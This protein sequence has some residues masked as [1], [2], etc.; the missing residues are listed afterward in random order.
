MIYNDLEKISLS[1]F[2]EVFLG[3]IDKVA[4]GIYSNKEKMEAVEKLCSEYV[5][6]VGG[7]SIS[8]NIARRNEAVKI[9]MR[10]QC[11]NACLNII[12][13]GKWKDACT[14]LS[15]L[16][17]NIDPDDH[18]KIRAKIQSIY[19]SDNYRLS[20]IV[21]DSGDDKE[22]PKMDREY[23]IRE[24]VAVMS[25]VKMHIDPDTF[26]AKEYAYLVK[27]TCDEIDAMIRSTKRR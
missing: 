17:Y 12:G 2:I 15:E 18:D 27:S 13:M 24:R 1:R 26:S 16:G 7:K 19:T 5:S 9:Q 20:K 10:I 21:R 6:I 25:H 23:F 14:I 3:D 22:K 4:D 8:A 11:L